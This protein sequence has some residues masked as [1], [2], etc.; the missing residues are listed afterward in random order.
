MISREVVDDG[1]TLIL[2]D[3]VQ[4][5]NEDELYQL[6]SSFAKRQ[7]Q[8]LKMSSCVNQTSAAADKGQMGGI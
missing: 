3:F 1:G 8:A 5:A 2:E 6:Q 4:N 7:L